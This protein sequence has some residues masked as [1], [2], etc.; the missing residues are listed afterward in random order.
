M[1]ID[2]LVRLGPRLRSLFSDATSDIG[3]STLET[4]VL[5]AVAESRSPPTVPQIG[6]SLGHL[7]QAVQRAANTLI[8]ADML[9]ASPNPD[10]KRAHFL[11]LTQQG[12]DAYDTLA[13]RARKVCDEF[14]EIAKPDHCLRMATELHELRTR[15]ESHVRKQTTPAKANTKTR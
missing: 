9:V 12:R 5:T 10:H 7:R 6:R 11:M 1:L 14:S 2:E 3:L 4:A 13:A 15:I 8:D